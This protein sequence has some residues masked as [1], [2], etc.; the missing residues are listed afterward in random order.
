[1]VDTGRL[2]EC[3]ETLQEETLPALGVVDPMWA[4]IIAARLLI[5][6]V[7]ER[8]ANYWWDSQVLGS[9][10]RDALG[11]TVPRTRTE[12]Q[13]SLA[14]EVGRTVEQDAIGAEETVSLFDLGPF[15]ESRIQREVESFDD[16]AD[17]STL[18]TQSIEIT[19]TEW[20]QSLIDVPV[21]TGA[22]GKTA[23]ELGSI[24]EDDLEDVS[25]LDDI[26]SR[27]IAGYGAATK[28]ELVVPYYNVES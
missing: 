5:E 22:T 16:E 18:E 25:V 6:R 3:F 9:F 12:A 26:V 15:A 11:D 21:E 28:H 13:I 27:L 19:D 1:M 14:T 2:S 20:T 17:F 23:H 24:S 7:G 4:R 8:D 10:G